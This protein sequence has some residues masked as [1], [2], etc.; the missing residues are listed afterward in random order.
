MDIKKKIQLALI[1][2]L[3][4]KRNVHD[5]QQTVHRFP[6]LVRFYVPWA[7]FIKM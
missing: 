6:D 1:I 7:L 4:K 2:K 3:Q 5:E